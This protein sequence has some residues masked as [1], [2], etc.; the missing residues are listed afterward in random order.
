MRLER[1]TSDEIKA[2]ALELELLDN[3][4]Y[5]LGDRRL[6]LAA[7][8][9]EEAAQ[10][11]YVQAGGEWEIPEGLPKN[12]LLAVKADF[13]TLERWRAQIKA[14]VCT[15]DFI[16]LKNMLYAWRQQRDDGEWARVAEAIEQVEERQ[17]K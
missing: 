9:A 3:A 10:A 17:G 15:D 7:H 12:A 14:D 8:R 16:E 2:A 13:E 5:G 11:L 1:P 4:I 6:Y